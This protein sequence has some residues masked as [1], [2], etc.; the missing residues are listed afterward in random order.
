MIHRILLLCILL[1]TPAAAQWTLDGALDDWPDDALYVEDRRG[2]PHKPGHGDLPGR[3]LVALYAQV[4]AM[5]LRVGIG[6]SSIENGDTERGL[7]L[8]IDADRDASTGYQR[9]GLG[10]ELVWDIGLREGTVYLDDFSGPLQG[11]PELREF[12]GILVA[13]TVTADAVELWLPRGDHE[14]FADRAFHL[15]IHDER[16]DDRAPENGSFTLVWPDEDA[17]LDAIPL[18]RHPDADLRVAAYNV[19]HDGL[20]ETDDVAR[21]AAL[22][23]VLG[24]IDADVWIFCEV[25]DHDALQT[26]D[27]LGELLQRD[28]SDWAAVR[29]DEGNVILSRHPV[30]DSWEVIDH[31]EST[32]PRDRHRLTAALVATPTRDALIVANHWRCCDAD[33]KRQFEAE[34]MVR[35]LRDAF[36]PGGRLDLPAGTPVVLGGD[37]IW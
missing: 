6:F 34:G 21:Q 35:F 36:A 26:R 15:A 14:L 2:D 18:T 22:R 27:R 23:R 25:W 12:L 9:K 5:A 19:E 10:C 24:A 30:K 1:V 11:G 28:L 37:F 3:D 31:V 16:S 7:L 32:N 20:F 13:P 29:R 17:P 4:D 33:A 8:L